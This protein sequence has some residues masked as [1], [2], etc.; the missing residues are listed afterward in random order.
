MLTAVM[1]LLVTARAALVVGRDL[2]YRSRPLA[3]LGPAGVDLPGM[4]LVVPW[5]D[6][7]WVFVGIRGRRFTVGVHWVLTGPS[8]GTILATRADL[9]PRDRFR[10]YRR[11]SADPRFTLPCL[12]CREPP[13][14]LVLISAAV[15]GGS[16]A[17]RQRSVVGSQAT[18]REQQGH[19]HLRLL[20]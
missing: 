8:T 3:V 6:I 5:Q 4:R 19:G 1:T 15:Q 18:D 7:G 16:S 9:A 2:R 14:A 17:G 12:W 20:A 11:M 10:L 13:E